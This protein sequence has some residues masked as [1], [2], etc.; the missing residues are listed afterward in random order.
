MAVHETGRLC[1][2]LLRT[3]YS[4]LPLQPGGSGAV[5]TPTHSVLRS[6][7]QFLK[8]I[9]ND[10]VRSTSLNYFSFFKNLKESKKRFMNKKI[11]PYI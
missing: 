1:F 8:G 2:L 6:Q 5:N 9:S 10:I 3:H 7:T 4:G 11:F